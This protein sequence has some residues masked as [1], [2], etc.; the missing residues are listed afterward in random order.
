MYFDASL[1]DHERTTLVWWAEVVAVFPREFA[2]PYPVGLMTF[3]ILTRLRALRVFVRCFPTQILR[4]FGL[5]PSWS[6]SCGLGYTFSRLPA[7]FS[8]SNYSPRWP[9]SMISPRCSP[10]DQCGSTWPTII[11]G[12]LLRG[13]VLTRR[14]SLFSLV[15]F[16]IPSNAAISMS[17]FLEFTQRE[18]RPTCPRGRN[19][20]RFDRGKRPHLNLPLLC[21]EW[22][23]R[24]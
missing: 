2:A 9:F 18:T 5:V 11:V 19:G 20:F 4:R 17:C 14:L 10:G 15:G 12:R 3:C 1:S 21:L 22:P 24:N 23:A 16:G 6:P 8:A 13:V 7:S